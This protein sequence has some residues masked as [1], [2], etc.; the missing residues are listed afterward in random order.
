M[1]FVIFPFDFNEWFSP[2]ALSLTRK[3]ICATVLFMFSVSVLAPGRNRIR[4]GY[5]SGKGKLCYSTL[6]E[7]S[8]TLRLDAGSERLRKGKLCGSMLAQR[9]SGKGNFAARR[10]LRETQGRETLRLD[11]GSERLR[12]GKLCGST[13]AQR[14]SGKGNFAARCWLRETQGRETL[15]LDA[16]SER[17]REGK[18][19]G[20]TLA[21]R[22]SG[23]GNFSAQHWLHEGKLFAALSLI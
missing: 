23:K 12:E 2:V 11:A 18:L 1:I 3:H 20:S 22:D 15:R 7:G 10:W 5:T 14:D 9:D 8:E 4:L 17:L 21:Q 6:A 16:G 19:C 13:L